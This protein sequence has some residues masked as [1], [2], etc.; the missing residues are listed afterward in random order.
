MYSCLVPRPRLVFGPLKLLT[1]S[2]VHGAMRRLAA[3]ADRR[4]ADTAEC[5]PLE[6]NAGEQRATVWCDFEICHGG[7]GR[8]FGGKIRASPHPPG[9]NPRQPTITSPGN[10][11]W[12][13]RPEASL[14][15]GPRGQPS[16]RARAAAGARAQHHRRVSAGGDARGCGCCGCRMS[17]RDPDL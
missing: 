16:G 6:D 9:A 15:V 12:G 1:L 10:D 5:L 4:G 17:A 11:V 13:Q 3:S 8:P 7:P 2:F 14:Q